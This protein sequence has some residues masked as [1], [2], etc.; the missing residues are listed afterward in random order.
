MKKF[1][2]PILC[3]MM[4]M[5]CTGN[6]TQ[7]NTEEVKVADS[8]VVANDTVAAPVEEVKAPSVEEIVKEQISANYNAALKAGNEASS[9]KKYCTPAFINTYNKYQK[10]IEGEIGDIDYDLW[11]QAQDAIKPSAEVLEV[12]M[13]GDSKAEVDLGLTNAGTK[14]MITVIAVKDGDSWKIDDFVNAGQSVA[15]IMKDNIKAFSE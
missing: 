7:E 15:K 6:K 4:I 11:L 13:K 5:S 9:I 1:I 12:T 3:A 8:T 2:L 10:A 14:S